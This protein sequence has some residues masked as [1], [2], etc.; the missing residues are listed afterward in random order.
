MKTK[1]N[2]MVLNQFV[3]ES[4]EKK[5]SQFQKHLIQEGVKQFVLEDLCSDVMFEYLK[6]LGIIENDG[7]L[8]LLKIKCEENQKFLKN[9]LTNKIA[10]LDWD[11]NGATNNVNFFGT[12]QDWNQTLITVI[13]TISAVIHRKTLSGGANLLIVSPEIEPIIQN[14]SYMIYDYKEFAGYCKLGTLGKRYSIISST[15]ITEPDV[16]IVARAILSDKNIKK[17]EIENYFGTIDILNLNLVKSKS[18]E[19]LACK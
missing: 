2:S 7:F 15:L 12:Q 17:T 5:I 11:Y 16:I 3:G 4:N 19:E 9:I 6:D 1:I 14:L 8:D 13:N 18:V 10:T